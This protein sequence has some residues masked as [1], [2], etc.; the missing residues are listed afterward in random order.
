MVLACTQAGA[1]AR[2]NGIPTVYRR[3]NPPDDRNATQG[4][5]PGTRA[6]AYRMVRTLRRAELTTNPDFHFG[7]GVV[8]YTQVTSPLRRF[9]DFV[10]H[11][12]IKGY[13]RTGRAPLDTDALL[14][15]FG[16]LEGRAEALTQV[17]REAKRYFTLKYLKKFENQDVAG[18]VVAALGSRGIVSL[19]DC[20]LELPV[21]GAGHLALGTRVVVRVREVDPRRDR[22]TLG[23]S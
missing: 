22:V 23:L 7:L 8:G 16:D 21:A 14:R 12:Q 3:Q 13:L 4:L 20:G 9:Q 5:K 15:V 10:E 11:V 18:E 2:A 1:F 17:E 19:D 6:F